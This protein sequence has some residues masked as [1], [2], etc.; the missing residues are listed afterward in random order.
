MTAPS[1]TAQHLFRKHQANLRR[2]GKD[3]D[4]LRLKERI[5]YRFLTLYPDS[6]DAE[7]EERFPQLLEEFKE[8]AMRNA[9]NEM[10]EK[11]DG[12]T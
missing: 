3:P 8:I 11:R 12:Q 5:R 2:Q 7:F 1:S 6:T 10:T 9:L 4:S